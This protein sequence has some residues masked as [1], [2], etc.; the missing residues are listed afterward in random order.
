MKRLAA[1]GLVVLLAGCKPDAATKQAEGTD[2]GGAPA[3]SRAVATPVADAGS[4][5]GTVSFAGKAPEKVEIDVTMDP[6]CGM[7][8]GTVY[9]EQYQV[10]AGKLGGVFVYV[11][12]G[13]AAAMATG[14]L[15]NRPGR[16]GPEGLLVCAPRH[17]RHGRRAGR[18][19][20]L[21]P[22]HA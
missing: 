22:H 20:Q 19:P 17:R 13:P 4:V 2:R 16:H 9:T 3:T 11:K 8:S 5:T 7:G 15:L 14:P 6:V 1:L 10:A 18:V 21:R 12:S